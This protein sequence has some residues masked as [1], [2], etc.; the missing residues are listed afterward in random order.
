[1]GKGSLGR[2]RRKETSPLALGSAGE[3]PMPEISACIRS[4]TRGERA[5]HNGTISGFGV[6]AGGVQVR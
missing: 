1:M 3:R 6:F 5:N 4:P 2:K